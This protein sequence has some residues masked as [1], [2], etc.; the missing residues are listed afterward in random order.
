MK[1]DF[2]AW[3]QVEAMAIIA[4]L[5]DSRTKLLSL[6]ANL[7]KEV[8]SLKSEKVDLLAQVDELKRHQEAFMSDL[9]FLG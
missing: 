4:D 2:D 9:D 8:E 3:G 6:N 5:S 7:R 1:N